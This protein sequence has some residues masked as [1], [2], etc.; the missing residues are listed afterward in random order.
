MTNMNEIED[1]KLTYKARNINYESYPLPNYIRLN[2]LVYSKVQLD[3]Y[4]TKPYQ[5]Q[6]CI[7]LDSAGKLGVL[8]TGYKMYRVLKRCAFFPNIITFSVS[9]K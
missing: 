3:A 9:Y 6:S 4:E 5:Q 2:T 8:E 1:N 7:I